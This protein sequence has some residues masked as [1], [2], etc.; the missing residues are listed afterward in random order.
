VSPRQL[1]N[2]RL[3][4]LAVT[5]GTIDAIAFVR[6]GNVF[7]SVITG[8]LIL[9]GISLARGAGRSALVAGCALAAYAIGVVT[10]APHRDDDQPAPGEHWPRAVTLVLGCD[11]LLLVA[12]TVGWELT[13]CRPGRLMQ[14]LL[15]AAAA[16]AMGA[17]STAIRRLGPV[18][19]TYLTSTYI[20]TLE[21]LARGRWSGVQARSVGILMAALGG[22]F[23]AVELTIHAPRLAPILA[24]I[25]LAIAIAAG[26]RATVCTSPRRPEVQPG[27]SSG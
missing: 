9:L 17:Q 4:L 10:C 20:A 12:L 16:A 23:A 7:A 13:E 6:L 27:D 19:T 1:S 15:L 11:L 8:N 24:L 2:L 21:A 5:S 18:S 25:P 26:G 14:L 3:T 22:A